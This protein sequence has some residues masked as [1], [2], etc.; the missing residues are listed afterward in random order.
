MKGL[1]APS[2]PSPC[3]ERKKE[4]INCGCYWHAVGSRAARR[5]ERVGTHRLRSEEAEQKIGSERWA[6]RTR[7][8]E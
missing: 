7:K 1:V 2:P 5:M 3:K 4:R 8:K 6:L